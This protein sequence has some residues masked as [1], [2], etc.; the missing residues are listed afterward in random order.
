[1]G[2]TVVSFAP[3]NASKTVLTKG[4][5]TASFSRSLVRQPGVRNGRIPA[6]CETVTTQRLSVD[7]LETR[8]PPGQVGWRSVRWS[9]QPPGLE[10]DHM[11]IMLQMG[12]Q[13]HFPFLT[14]QGYDISIGIM[15]RLRHVIAGRCLRHW[16]GER[17][18]K[19]AG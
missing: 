9:T 10:L 7:R 13:D 11:D 15:G 1:M 4:C 12:L 3:G 5:P 6:S 8:Q 16:F 17:V 14:G 19:G 18:G 2:V